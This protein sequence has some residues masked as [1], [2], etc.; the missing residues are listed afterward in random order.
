MNKIPRSYC[1]N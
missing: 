1:T